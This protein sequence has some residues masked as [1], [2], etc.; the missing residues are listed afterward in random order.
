MNFPLENPAF[1]FFYWLVNTPGIGGLVVTLFVGLSIAI[2]S[3]T[4]RWIQRGA[5]ANEDET[6]SYPTP[7]LH[8]ERQH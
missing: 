4:I 7:A 6:Y 3:L 5:D 1:S 2:Y 8:A